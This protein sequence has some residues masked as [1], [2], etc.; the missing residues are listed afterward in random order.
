MTMI[1]RILQIRE[2]E[3]LNQEKFAE[4]L[5][6]SRNF[7]NQFENGKKNISGRTI[8]DICREFNVNEE[9]LRTG[10]G[11]PYTQLPTD[12]LIATAATLLGRHDPLFESI[13]DVYSR[14]DD[15][16]KQ[17]LMKVTQNLVDTYR[18]KKE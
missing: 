1:D 7:I 5:G 17:V 3:C 13:I 11:E 12:D 15:V 8:S 16:D 14:L 18:E 6:L 10:N 9:W 2:H 4:R